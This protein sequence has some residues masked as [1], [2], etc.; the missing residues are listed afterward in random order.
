MYILMY[1]KLRSKVSKYCQFF[2]QKPCVQRLDLISNRWTMVLLLY[3]YEEHSVRI[4]DIRPWLEQ[5]YVIYG[6]K[7]LI[8]FALLAPYHE[9]N[10]NYDFV[11][12]SAIVSHISLC[13]NTCITD[14][15]NTMILVTFCS[16][17][18]RQL[19]CFF[20]N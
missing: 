20:L 3:F 18:L 14:D 1:R 19:Q 12:Y 11:C 9:T 10:E 5:P 8:F 4:S 2:L 15:S 16:I 6:L 7:V 17:F 13:S